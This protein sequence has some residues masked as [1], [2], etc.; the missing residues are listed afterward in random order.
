[1]A[2]S[3]TQ[4]TARE[5][6]HIVWLE[7]QRVEVVIEVS[8]EVAREEPREVSREV[9]H[10]IAPPIARQAVRRVHTWLSYHAMRHPHV[11]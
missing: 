6:L 2:L 3:D 8:S 5:L 11:H 10:E 4:E 7:E 1:M 9:S